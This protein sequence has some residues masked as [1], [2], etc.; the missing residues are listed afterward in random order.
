MD[1][2]LNFSIE[3][4]DEDSKIERTEQFV[5]QILEPSNGLRYH[6]K[7]LRTKGC[8]TCRVDRCNTLDV[9]RVIDSIVEVK[10]F[11]YAITSFGLPTMPRLACRGNPSAVAS[12]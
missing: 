8:G 10:S 7:H 12:Y 2:F 5:R 9:E 1:P 11:R 3:L 6:V 4:S